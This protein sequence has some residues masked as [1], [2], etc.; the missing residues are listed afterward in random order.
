MS[1]R[2]VIWQVDIKIWVWFFKRWL[3]TSRCLFVCLG[4][5]VP[6]EN[7]SLIW[8]LHHYR[9][10]APN[11]Y[12]HSMSSEGSLACH[13]YCDTEH[14]FIMVISEDPS[15]SLLLQSVWQWNCRNL[16]KL[17][18]RSV[19]AR[20]GT[21]SLLHAKWTL[22]PTALPRR[23]LCVNIFKMLKNTPVFELRIT[24]VH[25]YTLFHAFRINAIAI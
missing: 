14:P 3:S 9:W 13:T 25:Y 20:I 10:M 17:R 21:P 5:F 6:L 24:L 19:A 16:L 7:F 15:H 18:F 11:F 4:F 2:H 22:L 8:R 12:L 23:Q 1:R